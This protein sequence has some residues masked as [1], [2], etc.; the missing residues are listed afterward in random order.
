MPG[1]DNII[2]SFLTCYYQK[3]CWWIFCLD[4]SDPNPCYTVFTNKWTLS[5]IV[6]IFR[7]EESDL[8]LVF[9][10]LVSNSLFHKICLLN[11]VLT[12][13][14]SYFKSPA[15]PG[16]TERPFP[17]R[18]VWLYYNPTVC[19]FYPIPL[20]ASPLYQYKHNI[21]HSA[22]LKKLYNTNTPQINK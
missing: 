18:L 3:R 5:Q 2:F 21:E 8:P 10:I 12:Q 20:I 4:L 1:L 11:V 7:F 14:R 13:L 19:P 9:N 16:Y 6:F 17:F 22:H 15:R